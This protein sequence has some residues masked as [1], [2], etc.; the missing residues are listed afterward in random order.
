[1]ALRSAQLILASASPRRAELLTQLGLTFTV[2]ALDIDE[3]RRP[4]ETVED[5][6]QRLAATKADTAARGETLPVLGADTAVMIDDVL[7]GKPADRI[8]GLHMLSLLSGR[9][10]QVLTAIAVVHGGR[11]ES[12]MSRSRVTFREI[13]RAEAETYWAT[14]EPRD[15]AGGYGIQGIGGIFAKRIE[16][17]YSGIVGLPLAE[18]EALLQAFGVDTWQ[19]RDA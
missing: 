6:V 18:T 4:G 17:S 14:G 11:S 12:R 3:A 1:M 2:K 9:T 15:K 8:E 13:T 10:H 16:G 7:L 5:M 19:Y